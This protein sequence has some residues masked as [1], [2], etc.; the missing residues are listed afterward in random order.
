MR[1]HIRH[2]LHGS[3]FFPI[4]GAIITTGLLVLFLFGVFM[5]VLTHRSENSPFKKNIHAYVRYIIHDLGIPP[6]YQKARKLS[7]Q[8]FI[9]IRFESPEMAW[10]T[11]EKLP[12][13]SKAE[14]IIART[15]KKYPGYLIV[16]VDYGA[17][18]FHPEFKR[19][20]PPVNPL[21]FLPF[22]A[23]LIL[24]FLGAGL[25]I[26][27]ILHPLIL[28]NQ[29]VL[30]LSRGKLDHV[31]PGNRQ[32]ELGRLAVSFN[33]MATR[34]REMM[35]SKDQMLLDV[36]HEI[37]SPL[38]RM[39]VALELL[40][41]SKNKHSL[42]EDVTDMER[43]IHRILE[44]GRIENSQLVPRKKDFSLSV[45]IKTLLKN[46]QADTPRL[47]FENSRERGILHADPEQIQTV[48]ENIFENALKYSTPESG[49]VR[50]VLNQNQMQITLTVTDNG[51]GIPEQAL[52]RIFEPFYRVD[53]A[54]AKTIGGFGL[55]LSI[56]KRIVE[57]HAGQIAV[58]SQLGKG[59][60]ATL[61][62]PVK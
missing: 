28:L 37:R 41:P 5:A 39:K 58:Q 44:A 9:G 50:I 46:R 2:K 24:I 26:Q 6:D 7:Q 25:W 20:S 23:V 57:A 34:L 31:I 32:D 1:I 27:R 3:I 43:M 4:L 8:L 49:P 14:G 15:H 55:G 19:A 45:L 30:A 33:H 60:T 54:R 62:L 22:F 29:G 16:P 52:P 13:L 59:T 38:T 61:T 47:L 17:F 18:L 53:P 40:P 36:S 56:C 11:S 10:S 12:S 21:F 48:L 51:Q 35:K 42:K